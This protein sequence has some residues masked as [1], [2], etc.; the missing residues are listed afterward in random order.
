[1]IPFV[2]SLVQ[3]LGY[4][5]SLFFFGAFALGLTV[6][7]VLTAWLPDTPRTRHF[8]QRL[9]HRL[10]ALFLWWGRVSHLLIVRHRGF[11]RLP[12]GG[13]VVAANHPGLMDI[14]FLLAR[15]PEALC[16]FKP[17]IRHNPILGASA[18]RAGYLANDGGHDVVRQAVDALAAGNHLVIFPEGTRTPPGQLVGK[19]R[20]GFV[21]AARRAG[22][23][24]QLVR[25]T[26]NSNV[27]VKG[28]AWWKRPRLPARIEVTVGPRLHVAATAR[29]AE[30]AA[31]IEAWFA[32]APETAACQRWS[33]NLT[34]VPV[35]A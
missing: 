21:L 2:L 19:C 25:I 10:F 27:L 16:V 11:E 6:F 22:V 13:C 8:F 4:Y 33:E 7:S 20:P 15:L 24:I 29:P 34:V 3:L 1:V 26:W 35:S 32:A 5:L 23:P 31:E 9:I 17:A 30:V 12:T 18:R 14:T 28:R